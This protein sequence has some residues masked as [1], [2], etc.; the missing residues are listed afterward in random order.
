MIVMRKVLE[1]EGTGRH[2]RNGGCSTCHA[3]SHVGPRELGAGFCSTSFPR[4]SASI[5]FSDR[6]KILK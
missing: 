2:P 4:E 1:R 6:S 3:S 5:I